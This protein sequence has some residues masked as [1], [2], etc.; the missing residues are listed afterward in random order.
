MTNAQVNYVMTGRTISDIALI[1]IAGGYIEPQAYDTIVL[2]EAQDIVELERE[3]NGKTQKEFIDF[4]IVRV[5]IF[6]PG[7]A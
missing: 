2:N 4:N 1:R 6:K 7:I 3:K 5:I